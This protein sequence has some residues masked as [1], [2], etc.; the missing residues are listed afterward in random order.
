MKRILS[1]S[2]KIIIALVILG[3]IAVF[4]LSYFINPDRIKE[5]AI[6]RVETQY[7]RVLEIGDM[8]WR[9]FPRLGISISD[10]SLS[11]NPSFGDGVFAAFK[12]VTIFVDTLAL[13]G[14]NVDVKT[15]QLADAS[16]DLKVNKSGKSNWDDLLEVP[17]EAPAATA[18]QEKVDVK[19][20]K[21]SAFS[22]FTFNIESVEIKNAAF[23]YKD[24]KTGEAYEVSDLNFSSK[25]V[26]L[27]KDFPM[28]VNFNLKANSP[29]MVADVSAKA[30]MNVPA[31]KNNEIDMTAMKVNGE[32]NISK[33]VAEGLT[34]T[35]FRAPVDAADGVINM[36][37]VTAKL[38]GGSFNGSVN[39]DTN[40]EPAD[41]RVAYDLKN[42]QIG[43]MLKDLNGQQNFTG[44]LNLKGDLRFQSHP[45]KKQ[46]TSSLN[47]HANLYIGRGT[48]HG[49]DLTYWYALGNNM[50]NPGTLAQPPNTK[51]TE[52]LETKGSF[53]IRNG[54]LSNDDLILYNTGLYGAGAGTVNL[55]SDKVDYRFRLQGVRHVGGDQYE[56]AGAVIPLI[57][58]GSLQD[59]NI[60]PDVGEIVKDQVIQ[61]VGRGIL[62]NLIR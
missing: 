43:A 52:F 31:N 42:T 27:N 51:K 5:I 59:P 10:V 48:L 44:S 47:G 11:N 40:K 58:K 49:L 26:A 35:S 18:E 33:L 38:Y 23:T 16:A 9:V 32:V 57:I 3:V 19:D 54:V 8:R 60:S 45:G 17:D 29:Q 4:A 20:D 37:P 30:T 22:N 21:K 12:N 56:P 2:L 14:G 13:F 41:V 50:L 1:I 62:Q 6:N 28:D 7:N 15:M 25:D 34:I 36:S 55:V 24:E 53:N 46:L 61:G 39:I